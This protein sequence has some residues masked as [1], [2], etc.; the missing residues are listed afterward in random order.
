MAERTL[1]NIGLKG[2]YTDGEDGWGAGMRANL[3]QLSTS[4]QAVALSKVSATPGSPAVGDVYLFDETHPTHANALAVYDGATGSE[5]WSYYTPNEGWLVYNAAEHYYE[6]FGGSTW[7]EL[8]TGGGGSSLPSLTGNADKALFVTSD[9]SGVE[10]RAVASGSGGG[11]GSVARVASIVANGSTGTLTLSDIPQNFESLR[12]VITA[13]SDAAVSETDLNLTFN[14]DTG[15]HYNAAGFL[16]NSGAGTASIG[17][18]DHT[19]L[20]CV[21]VPGTSSKA[22]APAGSIFEVTNYSDTVFYKTLTVNQ[23]RTYGSGGDRQVQTTATGTWE[24]TSPITSVTFS[25]DSGNFVAGSRIDIFAYGESSSHVSTFEAPV[26]VQSKYAR[27]TATGGQTITLDTAPTPGNVM[28]LAWTGP[29]GDGPPDVPTGWTRLAVFAAGNDTN[30]WLGNAF[31]GAALYART[32]ESGDTGITIASRSGSPAENYALFELERFDTFYFLSNRLPMDGSDFRYPFMRGQYG[33]GLHFA[34]IENDSAYTATFDEPAGVTM[35]HQFGASSNHYATLASVADDYEGDLTGSFSSA[36]SYPIITSFGFAK[37]T[38]A[39]LPPVL[40]PWY[41]SPPH[42]ADF[43]PVGTVTPILTD[44]SDV[45]LLFDCGTTVA[46]DYIRCATTEIPNP[47]G[48][49]VTTMRFNP[50]FGLGNY[51]QVGLG[52][53]DASNATKCILFSYANG[54]DIYIQAWN[55]PSGYIGNVTNIGYR[56]PQGGSLWMRARRV[57]A[58]AKIYFDIS[59]DGKLWANI[60]NTSDTFH[61]GSQPT[62]VG[63]AT[64]TNC[65]IPYRLAMSVDHFDIT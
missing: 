44:D 15:A 12:I 11:G 55:V 53:F 46:G 62:F 25:L 56:A 8:E 3:L 5:A 54:G 58:D 31:Q 47:S 6:K 52:L 38:E 60:G 35:L 41:W 21:T 26:L 43:N 34:F 36:P 20:D 45:G 2:D 29:G 50:I 17:F 61:I 19:S 40:R 65:G 7:A 14:G 42:A 33:T 30:A 9:E 51:T 28:V 39:V 18:T 22:D 48:D 49:W 32:V 37:Y 13:R 64:M 57:V 16:R 10:W 24:D 4:V 63:P 59:V 1:P 23:S 27:I